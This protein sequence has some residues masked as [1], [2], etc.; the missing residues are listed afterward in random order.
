MRF[1][2]RTM[3]SGALQL[4]QALQAVVAVDD[5]AI[6]IVQIRRREA[7]AIERHQRTQFRRDHRHDRE[8]H[9][10]RACCPIR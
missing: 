4:H 2:L 9:P 1:S 5:A 10:F 3:M 7:A 6:E 8:D